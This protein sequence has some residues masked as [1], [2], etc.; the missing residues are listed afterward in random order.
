M[1]FDLLCNV[2]SHVHI[3]HHGRHHRHDRS[4]TAELC[5]HCARNQILGGDPLRNGKS[6]RLRWYNQLDPSLRKDAFSSEEVSKSA[7]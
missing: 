7:R 2:V 1:M 4:L 3:I 5:S 6:C